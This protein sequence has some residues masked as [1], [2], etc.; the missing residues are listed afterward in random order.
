MRYEFRPDPKRSGR[1]Q[2]LGSWSESRC[3]EIDLPMTAGSLR[4]LLDDG[5]KPDGEYTHQEIT[6]WCDQ[7][8]M[9]YLDD[10]SSVEMDAALSI[11]ADVDCQWDLF[12]ATS[13]TVEELQKIDFSKVRLPVAWFT[14]WRNQLNSEQASGGNGGQLS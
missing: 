13:Y 3:R 14:D 2:V 4:V 1:N 11:A 9:H 7:L 10:D 6:H 8:E 5:S 12:L